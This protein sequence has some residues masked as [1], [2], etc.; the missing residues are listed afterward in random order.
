MGYK[1]SGLN[2]YVYKIQFVCLFDIIKFKFDSIKI[3]QLWIDPV[4]TS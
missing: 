2:K 4:T 3:F 1:C